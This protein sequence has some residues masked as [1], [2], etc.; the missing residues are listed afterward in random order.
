MSGP[1]SSLATLVQK[2]KGESGG[3]IGAGRC[4]PQ[5]LRPAPTVHLGQPLT[6]QGTAR[7]SQRA[8][9]SRMTRYLGPLPRPARRGR[10]RRPSAASGDK[11]ERG[12]ANFSEVK[13][14]SIEE[15]VRWGNS[16]CKGSLPRWAL[17]NDHFRR[18][19]RRRGRATDH[20]ENLGTLIGPRG[21]P[22]LP[23]KS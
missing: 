10:R 18:A 6:K 11:P 13:T 4:R 5:V 7:T 23:C 17:S 3:G 22:C 21:R 15:Q 12:G 19:C 9:R 2:V 8:G 16:S 20:G 1:G 14:A